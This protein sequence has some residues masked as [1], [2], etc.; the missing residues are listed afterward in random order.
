L[1]LDWLFLGLIVMVVSA[2]IIIA[3]M[4]FS[5]RNFKKQYSHIVFDCLMESYKYDFRPDYCIGEVAFK[6]SGFG[7]E[8]DSYSGED[9][10]EVNIP[11]DDGSPS[12]T[13]L[14]VCD[15]YVTRTET[16]TVT[17]KNEDGSTST[18]EEEYTVTVYD[19]V[20]GYVYFPFKFKCNMS[21][22]IAFKGEKRIRLESL[23]FNKLFKVYTDNQLESL[24]I[25]TPAF[26]NK[27][28]SFSKRV[29]KLKVSISQ[30]GSMYFGMK[31]DLFK[32]KTF[33]KA[34]SGKVFERFYD[35]IYNI[36]LMLEEIKTNNKVFEM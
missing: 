22:N 20:F 35:D 33:F 27:L 4:K 10:L 30:S 11:N 6:A 34:P 18:K 29:S 36:V 32:L 26:M 25:L 17:V 16:R 5:W 23:K 9:L 8:Y 21:L 19:G 13:V 7:G 14:R 12:K 1:S 31:R 28:I 15:L 3:T 2:I 24:L